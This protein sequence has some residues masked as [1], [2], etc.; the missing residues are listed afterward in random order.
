MNAKAVLIWVGVIAVTI[1]AI[2]GLYFLTSNQGGNSQ[3]S[4]LIL[5]K[6]VSARDWRKGPD[7]AKAVLV[8]YGDF[9]CPACAAYESMLS[10]LQ[11]EFGGQLQIVFREFPL[12][13][14]QNARLAAQAAEAAGIQGKFWEMHDKLYQ[15]QKDWSNLSSSQALTTF[16]NYAQVL[17][18]NVSKLTS[19]MNSPA[20][21]AKIDDD[22]SS[23]NLSG[24]QGTPTFF[25]NG[26][27]A[28]YPQSYDEFKTEIQK[29]LQ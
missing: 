20:V 16:K 25:L 27:D 15:T 4:G 23:G 19:D 5:S 12:A 6:P 26:K 24:I 13:Q 7:G 28:G 8:E 14:H 2:V 21:T 3:N 18:L 10:Q 1:G 9:E 22:V 17:G 11:N 29:V